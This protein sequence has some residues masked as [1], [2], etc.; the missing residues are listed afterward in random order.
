MP[1]NEDRTSC[2]RTLLAASRV[3]ALYFCQLDASI[4]P[5]ILHYLKSLASFEI[6]D[7]QTL[8]RISDFV[9]WQALGII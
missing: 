2:F 8:C 1:L 3:L 6:I 7:S 4:Q 9:D 5:S